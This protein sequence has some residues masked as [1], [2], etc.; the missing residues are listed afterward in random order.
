MPVH[1]GLTLLLWG[2]DEEAVCPGRSKSANITSQT[3]KEKKG[4]GLTVSFQG[5]PPGT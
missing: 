5:T 4:Q 1:N 2:S 3:A